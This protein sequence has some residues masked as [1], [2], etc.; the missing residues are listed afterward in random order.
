MPQNEGEFLLFNQGMS[1]LKMPLEVKVKDKGKIIVMEPFQTAVGIDIDCLNGYVYWTDVAQAKI[2][3]ARYN[4]SD[5]EVVLDQGR[6]FK[7][8]GQ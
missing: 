4:G 1:V 8:F 6:L 7:K 5:I 2:K 3:R